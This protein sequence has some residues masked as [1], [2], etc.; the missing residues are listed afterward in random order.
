MKNIAWMA[1]AL[2]LACGAPAEQVFPRE[3]WVEAPNPLA[4]EF[5]EKGGMLVVYMGPYPKSFN[6]YLDQNVMSA[7]LFGQFYETLLSQHPVTLDME[8]LLAERCVLA[9]DLQTFTFHMNPRARWSDGRPVTAEDV[10]WTFETILDPKNLTGP[11][12]IGL[13]RFE[14]PEVLDEATIRFVAREIHWENL[15]TL[16]G[17]QVL[18]KHAFA[19]KDFNLQNFDFPVVSGPYRLGA[20]REGLQVTL[21]R[22]SDWWAAGLPRFRNVANF[23]VLR[24]RFFEERDNAFEAFK[25]G[26]IDLFPVY[27][28]HVWANQTSGEKYDRNW[29][30]KQ[31]IWNQKPVGFQGIALNQR[32]PPLDDPRV[33]RALAHLY[34]REKMN[35]TLMFNA[36]FLHRS[37][38]EDLYDANRPCPND[39]IPFDKEQARALLAE[40]GWQA[41]PA[42][43]RLAKDGQPLRLR[44]LSRGATDDKFTA[45][46]QEDLKD[47][48]IE[49]IVDKKDWAAWTKDM[50]EYSFDMTWAA[51]S[52]GIFK[53]PESM[54]LSKEADRPSGQNITGYKNPDVDALIEAQR[55][56]FDVQKRHD[57]VRRIDAIVTKDMPYVLL[58]NK[59]DTR[60]VWWNKFGLPDAPLGKFGDERSAHAYWWY[61]PDAAADLSHAM[62]TGRVLPSRPARAVYFGP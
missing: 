35:E 21:E 34:H 36:Y 48:G 10:R 27:T 6:Y 47:V 54:W 37:Y 29:L 55:T 20:I 8:P 3:G 40:A 28:A 45:I 19:G 11:H 39:G 4:S 33:R 1:L 44:Y 41:D 62:K 52:A 30:V 43:G 57:I 51:W 13:E 56:E 2:A 31:E 14:A 61:D 42:T 58:W 24:F 22:R 53:N 50:D 7:E 59:S 5:A 46:F 18:P 12:K 60:L 26:E 23:D 32:R 38:Y 15:L 9:D 17:L 49:L 16:A 25:K